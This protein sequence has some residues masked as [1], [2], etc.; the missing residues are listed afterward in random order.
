MSF[1]ASICEVAISHMQIALSMVQTNVA[2]ANILP[3]S[4][5]YLYQT[6]ES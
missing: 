1:F 3:E 5:Q 6:V 4:I 2:M